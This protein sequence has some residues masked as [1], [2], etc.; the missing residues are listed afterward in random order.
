LVPQFFSLACPNL[1]ELTVFKPRITEHLDEGVFTNDI[2]DAQPL[3]VCMSL[4]H[5]VLNVDV[6]DFGL[7]PAYHSPSEVCYSLP[8]IDTLIFLDVQML[9]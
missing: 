4:K 6:N 7:P 3:A 2:Q 5:L 1:A 8:N 9:P